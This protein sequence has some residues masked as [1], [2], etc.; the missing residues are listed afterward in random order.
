VSGLT[1]LTFALVLA[2]GLAEGPN[3][4]ACQALCFLLVMRRALL[5]QV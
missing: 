2:S 5:C 1:L 3:P 4:R